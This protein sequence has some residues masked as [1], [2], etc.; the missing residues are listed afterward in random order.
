VLSGDNSYTG[1]TT[2]NSGVLKV[3]GDTSS[4]VFTVNGGGTLLGGNGTTGSVNNY[5][6]VSTGEV[7]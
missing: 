5:G 7:L 2:V 1:D 3:S 6:N 4:S